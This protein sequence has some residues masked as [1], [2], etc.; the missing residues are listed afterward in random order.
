MDLALAETQIPGSDGQPLSIS[1]TRGSVDPKRV[2]L[3][4]YDREA[5][6]RAAKLVND[7]IELQAERR[8]G[9]RCSSRSHGSWA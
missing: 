6:Q 3:D 7:R 5:I 4:S 9:H 1:V 2:V 8:Y